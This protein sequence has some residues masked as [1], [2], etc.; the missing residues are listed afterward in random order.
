MKSSA[1]KIIPI[2]FLCLSLSVPESVFAFQA[3]TGH[4]G[5]VVHQLAHLVFAGAMGIL[6]YWLHANRFTDQKGWRLVQISCLLFIL[7]NVGAFV[8][9]WVEDRIPDAAFVGEP[10]WTQR[11][12]LNM[13]PWAPLYFVLKMDHLSCVPGI[14][15]LF[16]GIRLLFRSALEE[17]G[18]N[19]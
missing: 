10:D 5:L 13:S 2:F 1:D 12:Y 4:E 15:C 7:W 19:D 18:R 6:A 11:I 14:I 9:H 16:A 8:G 17:E 3:H